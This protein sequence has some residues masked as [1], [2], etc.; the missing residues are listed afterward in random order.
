MN[1]LQARLARLRRQLRFVTTCRGMCW[2]VAV[3]LLLAVVAGGLD[4][5]FHL[6]GLARAVVLVGGLSAAG[7]ILYRL[8]WL[9]LRGA[10]DDLAL[11]LKIEKA[12]PQLN[13]ALASAVQF[14]QESATEDGSS[15]LLRRFVV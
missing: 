13:D 1:P 5:R 4:W 9:P 11:A 2:L 8:L 6:P 10:S 14:T 3:L 7:V 12:Y 15:S